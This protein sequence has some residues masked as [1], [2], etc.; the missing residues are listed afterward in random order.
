MP[1]D[2]AKKRHYPSLF[3]HNLLPRFPTVPELQHICGYAR[4][5]YSD[6]TFKRNAKRVEEEFG[7]P[8]SRKIESFIFFCRYS[9]GSAYDDVESWSRLNVAQQIE[10][11]NAVVNQPFYFAL[12]PSQFALRLCYNSVAQT[13]LGWNR[14]IVEKTLASTQAMYSSLKTLLSVS[15]RNQIYRIDHYLGKRN[16]GI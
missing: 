14:F 2:L 1:R 16:G 4:S 12:P 3:S 15:R 10:E 5:D 8:S 7:A 11:N 9:R 13:K 6:A